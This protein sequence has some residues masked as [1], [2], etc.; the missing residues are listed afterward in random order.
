MSVTF[1]RERVEDFEAIGVLYQIAD[2]S[3]VSSGMALAIA[4][5]PAWLGCT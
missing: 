2:Q 5:Y 3:N 4:A 1:T